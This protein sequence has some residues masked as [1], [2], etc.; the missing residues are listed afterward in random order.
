MAEFTKHALADSLVKLLETKRLDKIKIQEIVDGANVNRQ[1]FYYHF[2]DIFALTRYMVVGKYHDFLEKN[3]VDGIILEPTPLGIFLEMISRNKAIALNIYKGI[4][5]SQ[6]RRALHEVVDPIIESE[7]RTIA[8]GRLAEGDIKF[9]V[10]FFSSGYYGILLEWLN[11]DLDVENRKR[12]ESMLPLL[13]E[14]LE[15]LV[16]RLIQ[17]RTI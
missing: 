2:S 10:A 4:E 16:E 15:L 14:S 8:N 6:L 5:E 12:M 17:N 11:D 1:T 7:V 13:E 3:G 9:A